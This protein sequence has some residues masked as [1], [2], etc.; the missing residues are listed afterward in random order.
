MFP[1]KTNPSLFFTLDSSISSRNFRF[2]A[3]A[4]L[5]LPSVRN[6]L[7]ARPDRCLWSACSTEI[8]NE[9]SH[10]NM[11]L[12]VLHTHSSNV[13]AQPSSGARCL[14]F[15]WNFRLLPYF[16][17]ATE[18]ALARPCGC[19]GLPEPLL[20]TGRCGKYHNLL[21]WLKFKIYNKTVSGILI[22][23]N[24]FQVFELSK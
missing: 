16:M 20:V 15:G 13:Y 23:E 11:V 19:A 8:S 6:I 22:F 17:C 3:A 14:I 1:S 12:S 21:S 7:L 2:L 9:L 10:R 4:E 24:S 18:K 5:T